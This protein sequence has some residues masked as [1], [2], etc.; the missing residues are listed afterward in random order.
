MLSVYSAGRV[1]ETIAGVKLHY[2][3]G[4]AYEESRWSDRAIEQYEMF[5]EIWEQADSD[6]S[7]LADARER[8]NRLKANP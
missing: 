6:L 5:L 4:I 3:L 7:V 1:A 8:L 2:Y